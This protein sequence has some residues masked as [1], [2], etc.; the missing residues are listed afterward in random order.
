[1]KWVIIL[2]DITRAYVYHSNCKNRWTKQVEETIKQRKLLHVEERI[3]TE[4]MKR[5]WRNNKN[6]A[7][8]YN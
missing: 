7:N 1:M 3:E 5:S 4:K 6:R 8:Y 2:P